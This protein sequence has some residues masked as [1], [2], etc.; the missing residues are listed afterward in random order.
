MKLIND[1]CSGVGVLYLF[2][3][4]PAFAIWD[5]NKFERP[6]HD[7]P[8]PHSDQT[9][10]LL[11]EFGNTDISTRTTALKLESKRLSILLAARRCDH[12][13]RRY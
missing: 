1:L 3:G 9:V 11:T 12:W 10:N 7:T 2:S 8:N 13:T 5:D 6:A 4:N